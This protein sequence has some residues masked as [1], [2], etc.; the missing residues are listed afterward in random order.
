MWLKSQ[1]QWNEEKRQLCE[2]IG[3]LEKEREDQLTKSIDLE[4]TG[5]FI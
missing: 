1:H 4:T 3:E 2:R 5:E